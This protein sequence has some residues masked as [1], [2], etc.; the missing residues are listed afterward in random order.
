MN[1]NRDA[2]AIASGKILIHANIDIVWE[3]MS[4]IE[5]WPEWNPDITE[6]TLDGKLEPGVTFRWK[7]GP[8]TIK[9]TLRE[10]RKPEIIGWSGKILGITALHVWRIDSQNGVTR[11]ST[12]ESWEGLLARLFKGWSTK[13]IQEAINSG[14]QH[15]KTAAESK[16]SQG[17]E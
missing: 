17:N 9:S 2:P 13:T 16:T 3:L 1:I 15:L 11:V 5:R 7:S 4:D 10:I 6:V 8:G 14:L 12:E